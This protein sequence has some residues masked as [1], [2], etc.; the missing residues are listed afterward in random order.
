MNKDHFFTTFGAMKHKYI[1]LFQS[2]GGKKVLKS[3]QETEFFDNKN[4]FLFFHVIRV[5]V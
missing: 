3:G 1:K 4:K 5:C 2:V